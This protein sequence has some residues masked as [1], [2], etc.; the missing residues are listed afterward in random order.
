MIQETAQEEERAAF[1]DSTLE[2]CDRL[3][4]LGVMLLAY[5]GYDAK[6]EEVVDLNLFGR[7]IIGR[8]QAEAEANCTLEFVPAQRN[9]KVSINE[10]SLEQ[11][12]LPLLTNA[13][14]S[15]GKTPGTVT[16]SITQGAL[17]DSEGD[18]RFP[19]DW[20]PGQEDFAIVSVAD[21]GCGISAKAMRDVFDPYYSDKFLGRGMG[22][23]IALSI[24][25][26]G[27]GCIT[28]RS[29]P[30]EGSCFTIVLPVH[31]P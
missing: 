14:E 24:A 3:R 28:A 6:Q 20:E 22:L 10:E 16:L 8:L 17:T 15:L 29:T 13:I 31:E 12:C 23:P 21:T 2:S 9:L 11:S 26:A 4:E 27:G 19:P 1:I 25:R 30:G 18:V 5:L 7:K